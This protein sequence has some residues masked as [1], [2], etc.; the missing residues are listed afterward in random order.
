MIQEPCRNCHSTQ[1]RPVF[2]DLGHQPLANQ[3]IPIGQA[4]D[5]VMVY[6]LA[7]TICTVCGLIQL[8]ALATREEIFQE[9]DYFSSQSD[10]WVKHVHD[11]ARDMTDRLGLDEHSRVLEVASNDGAMLREFRALG[12]PALGVEP[13]RN[14][15]R[16]AQLEGLA[17]IDEFMGVELATELLAQGYPGADLIAANNVMAHVPDLD[18]FLG[19]INML[20]AKDG[21]FTVEFP[22]ALTLVAG[23]QFD[24]I[25]HE[26]FSYFPLATA[27]IALES[28]GFVVDSFENLHGIHGGSVR[29]EAQLGDQGPGDMFSPPD[30]VMDYSH[31]PAEYR[32]EWLEMLLAFKKDGKKIVGYG[33]PAKGSTALNYA[34]IDREIIS[35]VVDST[36]AKQYKLLPGSYIP[37]YPPEHLD[38]DP[39]DVIL[40]MP[41][42]WTSEILP[43]IQKYK[44][45]GAIIMSRL[46]QV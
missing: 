29:V 7:P 25:Y 2:C 42:N 11:Y 22:D 30:W 5:P 33:A 19:G 13:A 44:D 35:Y 24:T 27:M 34:G 41:W 20:L 45:N 36:P 38:E 32:A 1:E 9:Y 6:P 3:Y 28:R 46:E 4:D 8:P 14:I 23:N 18:D 16:V 40:V 17:T 26:H 10:Q 39:P 12:I 43:K 37:I 15:A 31:K 21:V